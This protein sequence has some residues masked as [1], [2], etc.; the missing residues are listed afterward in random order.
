MTERCRSGLRRLPAVAVLALP[1][2]AAVQADDLG[3]ACLDDL[4]NSDA[5]TI[6]CELPFSLPVEERRTLRTLTGGLLRDAACRAT[7]D[8]SREALA[9]ALLR[10]DLLHLPR[11]P[12]ACEIAT[13]SEPIAARFTLA[14]K[15]WFADGRAVRATPGM[16]D[17]AGLPSLV[18]RL[19]TDWVNGSDT[20]EDAMVDAVNDYIENGLPE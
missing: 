6:A 2:A 11:Q 19:L 10:E 16:D 20:I 7:I 18:S 8:L 5:A 1:L 14:P 17:L 4:R 12:V 9:G 13:D 3:D 15:V